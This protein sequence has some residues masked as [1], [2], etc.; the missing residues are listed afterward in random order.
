MS[1]AEPKIDITLFLATPPSHG[2]NP[3]GPAL[4]VYLL[5]IFAKAIVSQFINEAGVSPKSADPIGIIASHIFAVTDFRWQGLSLIDILLAK[6]HVACP[7]LFGIYGSESTSEGKRR[8]GWWLEE[9]G[10]PFVP[11]QRHNERMTGLGAGFAAISLRNYEKARAENPFPDYHYWKALAAIS[12]V[13]PQ[14]ITQTHYVILKAMIEGYETKFIGFFGAA[15]VAALRHAL[16]DLPRMGPPS[17]AAKSL[18]GL[19]DVLR[20]E[21]KLAL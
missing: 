13:P 19:A 5:N 11:V 12:N 8:L 18:A 21:K 15:A 10:G 3:Y 17:V 6:L 9:P 1:L 4:L 7:P 16:I 2:D 14:E 20:M